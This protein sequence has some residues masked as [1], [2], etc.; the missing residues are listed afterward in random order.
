MMVCVWVCW[1]YLLFDLCDVVEC[2]V[3][4]FGDDVLELVVVLYFCVC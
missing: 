2:V 3:V 4:C 1:D